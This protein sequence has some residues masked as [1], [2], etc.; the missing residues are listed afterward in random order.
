MGYIAAHPATKAF[1]LDKA[2][3]IIE[4]LVTE[5]IRKP[6]ADPMRPT[7][8]GDIN[9]PTKPVD[10]GMSGQTNNKVKKIGKTKTILT[11]PLGV[12]V[13]PNQLNR[14]NILGV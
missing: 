6:M 1:A 11:T 3:P 10:G 4:D 2:K 12:A 8:T 9:S 5:N 13:D 7:M 14:R